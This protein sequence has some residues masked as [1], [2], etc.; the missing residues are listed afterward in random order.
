MAVNKQGTTTAQVQKQE[1]RQTTSLQQVQAARLTELSVEE[2]CSHISAICEDNP[3]LEMSSSYADDA[4]Q[5][6]DDYG[7]DTGSKDGSYDSTGSKDDGYNSR[8][9]DYEED[10]TYKP[11][12]TV[13]AENDDDFPQPQQNGE[14]EWKGRDN[15]EELTFHDMLKQQM[16]EYD[17]D[18]HQ[19]TIMEYLIGSLDTDG[20]LRIPL[21]QVADELEIYHGVYTNEE[22]VGKVLEVLQQFDPWGV[23]ARNLCECLLIQAKRNHS[24]P[25]RAHIIDLL[26]NYTSELTLAHWEQIQR[27]MKLTPAELSTMRNTL[28]KLNPKPGGSVGAT[29]TDSNHHIVPD[30]IVTIDEEGEAQFRLNE[31]TL[32]IVTLADNY[33][34]DSA[35]LLAGVTSEKVK[36]EIIAAQKFQKNRID[37]GRLFIEALAIRRHSM[38]VTMG[39]ILK[40]QK[41]YF[42]DGDE[43]LLKPM[44]LED[45]AKLAKLDISTV[46]RV[47]KSKSVETPYGNFP[48]NWFFT[49]RVKKDGESYSIKHIQNALKEIV[50]KE[51]KRKPYSDEALTTILKGMGYN[52][53]RRTVAKY[54]EQMGIPDSRLRR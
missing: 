2:L 15:G 36:Q 38:L 34:D 25:M 46:S 12:S 14:G 27:S 10:A 19:K 16:L 42:K 6:S 5:G 39:A 1:Q 52:V 18:E 41:E 44:I 8:E 28:K 17:L 50:S 9:E 7:Y 22:E 30:F 26:T 20:L 3:W 11:D 45:V 54:R 37:E 31:A 29:A 40:L 13:V 24:L 47:C 4:Y 33:T 35:L 48:L 53:A 21:E 32:P 23:G 43:T 49:S 51:N